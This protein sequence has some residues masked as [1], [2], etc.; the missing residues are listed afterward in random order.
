MKIFWYIHLAVDSV[1]VDFQLDQ[2]I[3]K[4][5]F[6]RDIKNSFQWVIGNGLKPTQ[7]FFF[8][9]YINKYGR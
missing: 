1:R 6:F 9:K 8:S 5:R 4:R 3:S 7:F 2:K